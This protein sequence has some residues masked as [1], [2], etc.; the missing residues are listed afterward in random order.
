MHYK[1]LK[2]PCIVLLHTLVSTQSFAEDQ[3]EDILLGRAEN[4]FDRDQSRESIARPGRGSSKRG[5]NKLNNKPEHSGADVYL[6][7]SSGIATTKFRSKDI[8][9]IQQSPQPNIN[10]TLKF[11]P[12]MRGA[13]F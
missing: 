1:I 3:F 12:G 13:A 7:M 5:Q 2:W 9:Y 6:D 8:E 11:V 4:T 10:D